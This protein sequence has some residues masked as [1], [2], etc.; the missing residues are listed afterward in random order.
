[1]A[2]PT[3]KGAPRITWQQGAVT[4][5]QRE[6]LLGQRGVVL[7]FTGLSG[8]GKSTLASRVERALYDRGRFAVVLDG[9]NL[10]HG[11]SN[12]LGFSSADRGEN[13]RRAGEVARL[14]AEAG[15]IAITALI[16]P[17]RADRERVRG[18]LAQGD[19]FEIFVDC[20][21]EVCA[22]RDPKGLYREAGQGAIPQFTG[23]DSPYEP[24]ERP[25][26]H[27]RTDENDVEECARRVL[28]LLEDRGLLGPSRQ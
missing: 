27:L 15:L 13:I 19:F 10:R 3:E 11:L 12:D 14:F 2:S 25:D 5:R 22:R 4:R 26:L 9:D 6:E 20:P 23:K 8:S 18:R 21:F 28:A 24:P 7:W 17:F 1:M 16:S